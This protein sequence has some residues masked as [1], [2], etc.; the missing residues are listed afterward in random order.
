LNFVYPENPIVH[1]QNIENNWS[2]AKKALRKQNVS[3]RANLEGYLYEFVFKKKFS[4]NTRLN[5]LILI[6]SEMLIDN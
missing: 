4:K 5:E 6:L 1:T 2:H 3:T